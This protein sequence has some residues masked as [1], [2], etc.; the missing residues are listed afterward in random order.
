LLVT[1]ARKSTAVK[2]PEEATKLLNEV[3]MFLRPGEARQNERIAK[4]S[5][6]ASQLYGMYF[7]VVYTSI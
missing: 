1:I 6:L 2:T 7:T 4:I 3:E 5:S